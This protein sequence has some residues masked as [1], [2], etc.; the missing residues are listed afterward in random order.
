[1][2]NDFV[3]L[4]GLQGRNIGTPTSTRVNAPLVHIAGHPEGGRAVMYQTPIALPQ[5]SIYTSGTAVLV[6]SARNA[7]GFM[8]GSELR[9]DVSRIELR[10]RFLTPEDW[11]LACSFPFQV[12]VKFL[13]HTQNRYR[14]KRMYHSDKT[15]V[16]FRLDRN[17]GLPRG[18][19]DCRIAL[20]EV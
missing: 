9:T 1:M 11:Q 8:I 16:L 10:W 7:E 17:T 18:Y 14:T 6:D 3:H 4:S 2:T 12:Y 5:C 20:I 13:D 15:S 19:K